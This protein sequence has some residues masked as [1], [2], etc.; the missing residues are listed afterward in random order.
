MLKKLLLITTLALISDIFAHKTFYFIP[1]AGYNENFFDMADPILNRDNLNR[2]FYDLREKLN[3]LGYKLMTTKLDK[4]LKDFA[5]LIV[6]HKPSNKDLKKLL[7]YPKQKLFLI[8]LEPP[9]VAPEYYESKYH[10]LF[11]KIFIMIDDY[12]NSTKYIKLHFPQP[13]LQVQ[14]GLSFSAKKLCTLIAS[15]KSS[16]HASELYSARKEVIHFFEHTAPQDFDFYGNGWNKTQYRTYQGSP[17]MKKEVLQKYKFCMCYENMK[18]VN[19][20]ITEKIFD[21]FTAGTVP[22]YWGAKNIS[23]FIPQ[24]CFIDRR[25]FKTNNEMYSFLKSVTE[26]QY[27]QYL[28]NIR[29]FL[30]GEQAHYFSSEYFVKS[31]I[32]HLLESDQKSK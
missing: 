17:L 10:N 7:K 21:V 25:L 29:T 27:N 32:R 22:V 15:N 28:A 14:P 26:E 20:Y 12:V 31:T 30:T 24:N 11:G 6:L 13:D 3:S 9:T 23:S 5:G 18:D 16:S 8:L 19:G 1:P 2:P 4:P